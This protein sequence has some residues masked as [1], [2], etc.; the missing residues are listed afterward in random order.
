MRVEPGVD[1]GRVRRRKD[2]RYRAGGG[3]QFDP[4]IPERGMIKLDMELD[5]FDKLDVWINRY[6]ARHRRTETTTRRSVGDDLPCVL[7]RCFEGLHRRQLGPCGRQRHCGAGIDDAETVVMAEAVVACG[8][9]LGRA[10]FPAV[11]RLI[12][13]ARRRCEDQ[14]DIP[15]GQILI[16]GPNQRRHAGDDRSGVTRTSLPEHIT[17]PIVGCDDMLRRRA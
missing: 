9:I 12:V 1:P 5:K 8:A 16:G 2:G 10:G 7:G 15:P 14:L 3:N 17:I 11:T 13:P 6:L 4:H